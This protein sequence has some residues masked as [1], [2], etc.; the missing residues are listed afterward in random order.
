[1]CVRS[2]LGNVKFSCHGLAKYWNMDGIICYKSDLTIRFAHTYI[3]TH[4]YIYGVDLELYRPL[5]GMT[6]KL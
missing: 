1:M 6:E 4:I 5:S 2:R 3:H